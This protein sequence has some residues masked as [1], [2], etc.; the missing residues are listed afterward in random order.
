[1]GVLD[2]GGLRA[3]EP[4]L[5]ELRSAPRQADGVVV[6]LGGVTFAD[7]AGLR[8]VLL[9]AHAAGA[10][11]EVQRASAQVRRL[12][13]RLGWPAEPASTADGQTRE[14]RSSALTAAIRREL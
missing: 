11:V 8:T 5:R 13:A 3:I 2:L 4:A 14:P 6:D 12:A 10:G 7:V 9:A 1:A